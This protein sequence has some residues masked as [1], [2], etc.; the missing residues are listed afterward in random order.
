[1]NV[2]P[3]EAPGSGNY[4]QAELNILA[5]H[6]GPKDGVE[7]A[8][9]DPEQLKYEWGDIKHLLRKSKKKHTCIVNQEDGT[10]QA[11]VKK[12]GLSAFEDFS[13]EIMSLFPTQYPNTATLLA[14]ASTIP[15][16]SA[17]CER[18]FSLQNR[19]K[20]K[21][22]SRLSEKNLNSL[23]TLAHTKIPLHD[24]EFNKAVNIWSGKVA[25]KV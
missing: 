7:Q 17:E 10:E 11:S 24:F 9:I 3:K 15:M 13:K 6:Y 22:R 25:R 18:A 21:W 4:G 2:P 1:M 16:S 14:I 23:M 20:S 19:I 5:N 8:A 12:T